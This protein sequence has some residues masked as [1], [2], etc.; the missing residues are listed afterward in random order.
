[1]AMSAIRSPSDWRDSKAA[2]A[3]IM[4]SSGAMIVKRILVILAIWFDRRMQIA[5]PMI[6]ASASDQTIV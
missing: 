2:K 4:N 3:I 6:V 1:M 5:A